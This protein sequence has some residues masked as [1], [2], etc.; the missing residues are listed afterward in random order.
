[1][2]DLIIIRSEIFEKFPEI[3]FGFSTKPGGVSTEPY[4]L[5]LSNAVGDDPDNVSANRNLF[6]RRLGIDE[7]RITFQKQIHSSVVNYSP[8]PCHFEGCD[9]IFTDKKNNFLAVG[10]ADCIPV[11]LYDPVSKVIAGIHSGWKGT[12]EKILTRTISE[13]IN[14]FGIDPANLTAYIG[15]GICSDHY[16]V[17]EEVGILF[18]EKYRHRSNG[19]YF[20]DLK[21]DNYDQLINSGVKHDSIEVSGLCTFCEKDL[22]HSYRRDGT[23][24]GRMFGIIGIV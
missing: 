16:E 21:K 20:L 14:K 1:M 19:K 24:S 23:L 18:N 17:G 9:A 4:C 13:L 6:F 2:S 22:L 11:F 15:P 8:H 10:V 5:N 12:H 3:I 7:N